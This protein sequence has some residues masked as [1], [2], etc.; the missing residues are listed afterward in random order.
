MK[1]VFSILIFL[2]IVILTASCGGVRDQNSIKLNDPISGDSVKIKIDA[3]RVAYGWMF[4]TDFDIYELSDEI[5][6]RN[7]KLTADV[8]QSYIIMIT[9]KTNIFY[10]FQ[11][12]EYGEYIDTSFRYIAGS[13]EGLFS[14]SPAETTDINDSSVTRVPM[15]MPYHML[16][17]LSGHS[18]PFFDI[19]PVSI[20]SERKPE[21]SILRDTIECE[22]LGE[23]GDF[24]AFYN[25]I[26]HCDIEVNGD[27]L[28]VTN[29][30]NGYVLDIIFSQDAKF[31]KV[32]VSVLSNFIAPA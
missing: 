7:T 14:F 12:E 13:T 9:T 22:A 32:T 6:K 28:L 11:S 23:P 5:E 17:G 26:K 10:I 30:E 31:V 2:I 24:V 27:T 8:Y 20:D 18:Y 16:K 21:D 25:T 3:K 29:K 15:Y 1:K 19:L 4:S